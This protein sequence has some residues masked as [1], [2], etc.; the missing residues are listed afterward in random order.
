MLKD[1]DAVEQLARESCVRLP[2]AARVREWLTRAVDE[3]FGD[4]DISQIVNC[5]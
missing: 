5:N 3:G 4:S 2:I 1:L